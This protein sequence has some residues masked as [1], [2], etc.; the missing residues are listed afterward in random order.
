VAWDTNIRRDGGWGI[1]QKG[2]KKTKT[3]KAMYKLI[4][5]KN[6]I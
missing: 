4:F 2:K 1:K 6:I 5:L 3:A